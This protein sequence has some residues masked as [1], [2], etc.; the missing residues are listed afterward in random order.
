MDAYLDYNQI[1]LDEDDSNQRT[2]YVDSDIYH[3]TV[4]PFRLINTDTTYQRMVNKLFASMIIIKM[5]V[6]IN[7]MFVN[8]VKCINHT[9]NLDK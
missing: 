4:M 9:S 1:K 3:Y 2:F 5:E 7:D 6:Y 8:L